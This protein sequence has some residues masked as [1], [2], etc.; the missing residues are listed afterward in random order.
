MDMK[1]D[2][3][4]DVLE[5]IYDDDGDDDDEEEEDDIVQKVL[6]ELG[7]DLIAK[8]PTPTSINNRAPAIASKDNIVDLKNRLD[9]LR[10]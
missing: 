3:L 4:D 5:E 2:L 7:L 6:D 1:G 10:K 8:L 9:N